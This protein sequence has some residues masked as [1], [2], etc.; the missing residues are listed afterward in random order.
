MAARNE[1]GV[2]AEPAKSGSLRQ[3]LFHQR[4]CIYKHFHLPA[5]RLR[6]PLCE[7]F[8]ALFD[9]VMIIFIAGVNGDIAAICQRQVLQG[10]MARPIVG[11]E[12]DGARCIA[13]HLLWAEA[14]GQR[15]CQPGHL[16]MMAVIDK[17]LKRILVLYARAC[18]RDGTAFK[19]KRSCLLFEGCFA[20]NRAGHNG[21]LE[22][23]PPADQ[24]A[25][26]ACSAGFSGVY[27]NHG[28]GGVYPMAP[29]QN[30][31]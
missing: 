27:T 31:Q 11:A 6:Y 13:P 5:A 21:L 9:H 1:I 7:L 3:R 30:S 29:C 17:G 22:A 15:A 20:K 28:P 26:G 23:S 18:W 19:A 14:P 4:R 16:A 24:P 8:E 10:I 25:R 12:H 2:L